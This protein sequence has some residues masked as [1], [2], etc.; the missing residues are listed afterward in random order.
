[1]ERTIPDGTLYSTNFKYV[2]DYPNVT[3]SDVQVQMIYS[4][5]NLNRTNTVIETWS[6]VKPSGSTEKTTGASLVVFDPF[7]VARPL[8]KYQMV[9]RPSTPDANFAPSTYNGS[10]IFTPYGY[11][12][13]TPYGVY[14][15]V[16][17]VLEYDSYDLPISAM[18]ESRVAS[19]TL[20]GYQKQLPVA[21]FSN[22]QSNGIAFSDFETTTVASFNETN[23]YYGVGRTGA[24]AVHPYV[25][26][27]RNSIVKATGATNYTLAFWA[28]PADTNGSTFNLNVAL[29]YAGGSRSDNYPF[30]FS[31]SADYQY[32]TQAINVASLPSTFSVSIHGTSWSTPAGVQGS[33]N[34]GL[35][36][37]LD[38]ISLIPDF[39]TIATTTYDVPFGP[40]SVTDATGI[41]VYSTYDQVGR[42][43][44]V[45]DQDHNIRKRFTYN[46]SGQVKVTAVVASLQTSTPQIVGTPIVFTA[47]PNPCVTGSVT[48]QWDF[49]DGHGFTSPSSSNVSPSHTYTSTGLVNITL[50]VNGPGVPGGTTST[51]IQV[52]VANSLN[53]GSRITWGGIDGSGWATFT[54]STDVSPSTVATYHWKTRA[55][56]VQ[57]ALWAPIGPGKSIYKMMTI[58][59]LSFDIKCTITTIDGQIQD[60]NVITVWNEA[61]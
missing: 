46:A 40:S 39:A 30:T 28:K 59:G 48:Y 11:S 4:L 50:Q 58:R 25:T 31:S 1:V 53:I 10:N 6:N 49:N 52:N 22:T 23:S 19:G 32:F 15:K 5:R 61:H 36:P 26:L 9:Y 42:T 27:T 2:Q 43:Q 51:L 38:D 13:G 47:T 55:T 35:L 60:S 3:S 20:L 44:W 24:K 17:T 34:A 37:M 54:A 8:V 21:Q 29:T 33:M 18:G 12:A 56:G 41:T 7:T 57:S 16:N 14:E 45:N